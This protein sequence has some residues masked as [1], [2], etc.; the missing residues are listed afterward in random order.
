MKV[1]STKN[2]KNPKNSSHIEVSVVMILEHCGYK[3]AIH[4]SYNK[5]ISCY[6]LSEYSTGCVFTAFSIPKISLTKE[7]VDRVVQRSKDY[8]QGHTKSTIKEQIGKLPV[9]N[10]DEPSVSS[11]PSYKD[12]EI[13]K[14]NEKIKEKEIKRKF[15][16]K[17][18]PVQ[19]EQPKKKKRGRPRKVKPES[20]MNTLI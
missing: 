3:F 20:G 15:T 14:E 16:E 10:S 19:S 6:M 18:N 11:E 7:D 2:E 13:A 12:V 8:L 9:V 5:L 4:Q 17:K 1:V